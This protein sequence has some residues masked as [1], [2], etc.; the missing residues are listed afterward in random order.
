MQ[1]YITHSPSLEVTGCRRLLPCICMRARANTPARSHVAQPPQRLLTNI[2]T[3]APTTAPTTA[4]TTTAP[5]PYPLQVLGDDVYSKLKWEAGVHRVQRVPATEAAG[6]VHTSTST[7]A[8]MPEVNDVDV[9]IDMRDVDVKF[10][11]A[12]GAG[13]QNVNKV[14]TAVDLMHKPTGI[15]CGRGV[16]RRRVVIGL[17]CSNESPDAESADHAVV[18]EATG[19]NSGQSCRFKTQ[20]DRHEVLVQG[21]SIQV[22]TRACALGLLGTCPSAWPLPTSLTHARPCRP[23]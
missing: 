19:I 16:G 6:R 13:G 9:K 18:A 11:R 22:G 4:L 23:Q 7:V 21:F 10:A 17:I 15:R 5:C 14:E 1:A 8:V 2:I 12:S 3:T 20:F